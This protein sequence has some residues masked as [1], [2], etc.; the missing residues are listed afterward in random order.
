MWVKAKTGHTE[1][2]PSLGFGVT[3]QNTD[4]WGNSPPSLQKYKAAPCTGGSPF[5]GSAAAEA[6]WA[7]HLDAA[8]GVLCGADGDFS[9]Q[10]P[11]GQAADNLGC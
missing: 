4:V 11:L 3:H 7:A 2:I 9:S 8:Q 6:T 5:W 10:I 1:P